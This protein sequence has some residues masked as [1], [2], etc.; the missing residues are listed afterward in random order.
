VK[1]KARRPLPWKWIAGIA[2]IAI[3]VGLASWLLPLRDWSDLL[4][5][6]IEKMELAEGLAVFCIAAIAGSLLLLPAWIFPLLAGAL[7]GFGWG[8][9]AAVVSTVGGALVAFVI[10][11]YL[12][13]AQV[14]RIAKRS[15]TFKAVDQAVAKEPWKVV[16]LLRLSPVLPSGAK[17]YFLG[18]T[19]VEMPSYVYATV[20]GML[21]GL[22]LK[23]YVGDAG[24]GALSHGGPLKWTVFAAG[25][26]ATI[27]LTVIVGRMVRKKLNL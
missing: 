23:V 10:G 1:K 13:R 3:A 11:R 19:C 6:R 20:A 18:L 14:E 21:P 8:L 4:A 5:D 9:L 2:V 17:S 25:L 12:L 15:D 27:T 7:F 24:R 22:M 16:A 26:A